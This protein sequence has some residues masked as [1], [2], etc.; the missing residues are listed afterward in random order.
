MPHSPALDRAAA[1]RAAVTARQYSAAGSRACPS[2]CVV[3]RLHPA[4]TEAVHP[5]W[6]AA[7]CVGGRLWPLDLLSDVAFSLF[8]RR[9]A[10][11]PGGA[12]AQL[13]THYERGARRSCTTTT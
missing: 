13:V 1:R 8:R 3:C 12:H 4:A 10:A 6:V 2:C 5:S 7:A 11:A 9:S